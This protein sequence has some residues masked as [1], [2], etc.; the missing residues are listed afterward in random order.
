MNFVQPVQLL[1]S[2]LKVAMVPNCTC[3]NFQEKN[4]IHALY[5]IFEISKLRSTQLCQKVK[6]RLSLL[7]RL[8]SNYDKPSILPT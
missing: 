6:K 8:W 3:N 1:F 7:Q 4:L 5:Q 2:K